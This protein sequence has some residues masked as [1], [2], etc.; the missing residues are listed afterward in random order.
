MVFF[1]LKKK[2]IFGVIF[3]VLIIQATITTYNLSQTETIIKDSFKLEADIMSL[4]LFD[5][6]KQSL[7]FLVEDP[8]TFKSLLDFVDVVS[9]SFERFVTSREYLNAISFFAA[10]GKILVRTNSDGK[11]ESAMDNEDQSLGQVSPFLLEKSKLKNVSAVIE[12]KELKIVIPYTHE[13]NNQLLGAFIFSYSMKRISDRRNQDLTTAMIMMLVF[14][15]IGGVGA[16][17][18]SQQIVQKIKN[19]SSALKD[20]SS[21]EG[22]LTR[23]LEA[24]THDEVGE[25][26]VYFNE[27]IEKIHGIIKEIEANSEIL[28][29]SSEELS[30][31]TAEIKKAADDIARG[32]ED[33]SNALN[34]SA[35]TLQETIN[36]NQ[37][38]TRHIQEVQ[39]MASTAEQDAVRG[40]E[41]ILLANQS[42]K[43]IED[44]GE[45]I[46]KIIDVITEIANQTNLLSLNA[47]IEAAKAGELGKG[48]AV[49]AEEIR[50]LAER[51]NAAAIE[52]RELIE[53]STSNVVD[54]AKVVSQT[55]ETLQNIIEQF[56]EI[57]NQI[58]NLAKDITNQDKRTQE[59][60]HSIDDINKISESNA[61]ATHEFSETIKQVDQTSED[62]T[63]VAEQLQQQVTTFRI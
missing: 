5:E 52:I 32:T 24:T 31:T 46:Q 48:F 13:K 56:H 4:S 49:V 29:V 16:I 59:I 57:A 14:M 22:D 34:E 7:E 47:A 18:L 30:A 40:N 38:I 26:A 2:I 15:I 11:R 28:V 17:L 27:F 35:D 55:G 63:Q 23:R 42:M 20:I 53:V 1:T 36:S 62:L 33:E 37:E 60:G 50:K 21:G 61:V 58:N 12:N 41:T 9:T 45:Q 44:S 10:D 19:V 8:I 3:L 51:S 39:Q 54:G 25:L 6:L 43:K